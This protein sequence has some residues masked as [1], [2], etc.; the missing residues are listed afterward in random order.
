MNKK[1]REG[2]AKYLYDISKGI[3]I[4]AIVGNF[5]RETWDFFNIIAGGSATIVFFI[6]AHIL[7]G[8]NDNE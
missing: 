8:G 6:W 1:Q 4:V 5:T 7:Q 2:A 3:S